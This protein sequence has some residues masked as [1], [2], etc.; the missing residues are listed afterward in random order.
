M[1]KGPSKDKYGGF[2]RRQYFRYQLLY[3]PKEAKLTID[4]QDYSVLD[5]SHE[6]IRFVFDNDISF[7][8][9]VQGTLTFSDGESRDVKGT[10]VWM[11][12]NEIGL[13]LLNTNFNDL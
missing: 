8:K 13:K 5:V 1:E 9:E 4:D 7:G 3:S 12:D 11:Q 10:V 6:G 2:E